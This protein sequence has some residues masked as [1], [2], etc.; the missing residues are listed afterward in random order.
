M[1]IVKSPLQQENISVRLLVYLLE[2]WVAKIVIFLYLQLGWV[3]LL[4]GEGMLVQYRKQKV[5]Y[6]F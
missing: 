4:K 2:G 3:K 6:S 5:G 1:S